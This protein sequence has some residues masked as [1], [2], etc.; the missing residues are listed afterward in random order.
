MSRADWLF[1]GLEGVL[2]LQGYVLLLAYIE[3]LHV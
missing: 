2:T 1:L 3:R